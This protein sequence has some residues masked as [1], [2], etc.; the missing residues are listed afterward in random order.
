M[1]KIRILLVTYLNFG[2]CCHIN[3]N[4]MEHNM[5]AQADRINRAGSFLKSTALISCSYRGLTQRTEDALLKR[6]CLKKNFLDSCAINIYMQLQITFPGSNCGRRIRS[7]GFRLSCETHHSLCSHFK[8]ELELYSQ[9]LTLCS[10]RSCQIDH[11]SA[12]ACQVLLE[13]VYCIFL[14]SSFP[15]TCFRQFKR[16]SNG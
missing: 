4:S 11:P 10:R 5:K 15:S 6:R 1:F 7:K 8:M 9:L 2:L 3:R 13:L 12:V 14:L 16:Y